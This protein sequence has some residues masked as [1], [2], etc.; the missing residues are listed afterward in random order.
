MEVHVFT[1]E[2]I[3]SILKKVDE[4]VDG[5]DFFLPS[6]MH[7]HAFYL[8]LE[9]LATNKKINVYIKTPS[10]FHDQPTAPQS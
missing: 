4:A 10:E 1:G 3:H 9:S 5:S 2:W 7:L 8:A 6:D